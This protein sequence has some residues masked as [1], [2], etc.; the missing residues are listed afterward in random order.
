MST[1]YMVEEIRRELYD[2]GP[3][4]TG[5]R[6]LLTDKELEMLRG[7][8]EDK[9][10]LGKAL[11]DP[12]TILGGIPLKF[13]EGICT[14]KYQYTNDKDAIDDAAELAAEQWMYR[15]TPEYKREAYNRN[16]LPWWKEAGY[17]TREEAIADDAAPF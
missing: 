4:G 10:L 2:T 13:Y 1:K 17:E 14:M 16:H 15:Q 6:D 9:E 12:G 5:A 3:V 11:V 8:S 7:Y